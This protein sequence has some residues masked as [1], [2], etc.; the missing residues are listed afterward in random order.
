MSQTD[1]SSDRDLWLRSR[2]TD[3]PADEA[4]RL[5]DIAGFADGLLD[6]DERDRVAA[7][8]AA[9]PLAAADAAAA[10]AL[11]AGRHERPAGF[12]RI[13]ARACALVPD[14]HLAGARVIAFTPRP[15]HRRVLHGLAQWGSLAAA[16]LVASWLGFSMGSDTSLAL[17]QPGL[18]S[19]TSLMPELFDPGTSFLRDFG[20]NLRS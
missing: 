16:I 5:L 1:E 20:E 3:A 10:H 12:E 18:S 6:A 7:L 15:R 2:V 4:A 14:L 17:S 13:V 19:D 9:D 8:L 11:G